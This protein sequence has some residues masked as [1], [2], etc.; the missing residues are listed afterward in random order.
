MKIIIIVH[1]A[2]G[3][4]LEPPQTTPICANLAA[5]WM[6]V[7]NLLKQSKVNL[8]PPLLMPVHVA[9]YSSVHFVWV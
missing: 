9:L 1:D 6:L 7:S 8:A 2:C 4:F 3:K 5:K